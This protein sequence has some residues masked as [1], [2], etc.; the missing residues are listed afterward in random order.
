MLIY[1]FIA[2]VL[3]ESVIK[4]RD[5][6]LIYYPKTMEEAREC[7]L[8]QLRPPWVWRKGRINLP[9]WSAVRNLFPVFSKQAP[10]YFTLFKNVCFCF[11]RVSIPQSLMNCVS[12]QP[13]NLEKRTLVC[14]PLSPQSAYICLLS[15]LDKVCIQPDLVDFEG[16]PKQVWKMWNCDL[17]QHWHFCLK[18]LGEDYV[19][20]EDLKQM[21]ISL[22]NREA[23]HPLPETYHLL[24]RLSPRWQ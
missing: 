19:Y 1:I 23:G 4:Y 18:S 21:L 15:E 11:Y 9:S 3:V 14:V 10:H 2:L 16:M 17:K 12:W 5:Q 7:G 8:H 6:K 22:I 13:S 20:L 24:E